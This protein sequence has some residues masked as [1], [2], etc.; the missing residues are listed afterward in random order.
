MGE[1]PDAPG[2]LKPSNDDVWAFMQKMKAW[3]IDANRK[4]IPT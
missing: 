1:D 4:G 2:F 3:L